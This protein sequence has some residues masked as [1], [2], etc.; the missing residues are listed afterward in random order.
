MGFSPKKILE[1]A[2]SEG[3]KKLLEHESLFLCSY[4]DIPVPKFAIASNSAEAAELAK[5]I[6][7]PVVLKVIS[8][9]ILHKS[10][11]GGVILDIRTPEEAQEKFITI[12]RNIK[13]RSPNARVEGVLIQEMLP[14]GLEVIVG[15]TRDPYFGPTVMFGVGGVFVEVLKDVS[16]RVAPLT[17]PDAEEMIRDVRGYSLFKGYRGEGPRDEAAVVDVLLKFS[18]L[19]TELEEI[20]EADLN[21][22]IVYEEGRGVKVAD[23]RFILG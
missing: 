13:L 16:F 20:S 9:D 4:Y 2:R 12:L 3:R 22:L 23:A 8:P 19:I 17:L 10:D 6:G 21:P 5:K 11:V 14:K 1:K 18:R 15:G 7:F